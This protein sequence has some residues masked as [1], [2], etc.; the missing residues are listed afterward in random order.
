MEGPG[1]PETVAASQRLGKAAVLA[2][3]RT[4]RTCPRGGAGQHPVRLCA[5]AGADASR[6]TIEVHCTVPLDLARARYRTRTGHRHAGHLDGARSDQELRVTIPT[7]GPLPCC[8]GR[9]LRSSRHCQGRRHRG[10]RDRRHLR[11]PR[12]PDMHGQ[13][14]PHDRTTGAPERRIS[15]TA[16]TSDHHAAPLVFQ[17]VSEPSADSASTSRAS[18]R[19]GL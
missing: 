15:R 2:M 8:R 14:L 11:P 1:R 12:Y 18:A 9:Y 3:L 4:A 7:A 10:P 17:R 16:V 19:L 13:P 5:P 6:P